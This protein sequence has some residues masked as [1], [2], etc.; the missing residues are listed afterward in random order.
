LAILDLITK[1]SKILQSLKSD[2]KVNYARVT[3]A[4]EPKVD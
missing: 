4:S 1:L 2:H 3:T